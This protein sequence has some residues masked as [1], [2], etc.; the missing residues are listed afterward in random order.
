M[1]LSPLQVRVLELHEAGLSEKEIAKKL[2]RMTKEIVAILE[3]HA[4]RPDLQFGM[5]GLR[6]LAKEA[7]L[8]P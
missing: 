2:H 7:G 8:L 1:S 3:L 6:A 4:K 5:K